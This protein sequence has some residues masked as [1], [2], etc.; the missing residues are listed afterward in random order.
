[1]VATLASADAFTAG[2]EILATSD[3]EGQPTPQMWVR[4][5]GRGRVFV[6]LW[7]LE[8]FSDCPH[9]LPARRQ[10]L[11]RVNLSQRVE[12]AAACPSCSMA[13]G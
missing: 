7:D 11:Q 9:C 6:D 1:M 5:E 4:E 3:E 10:R 2:V 13:G 8:R 12:P